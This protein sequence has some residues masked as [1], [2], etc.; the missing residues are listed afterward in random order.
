MR[1]QV[2]CKLRVAILSNEYPPFIF[3]GIGTFCQ[4]LAEALARQGVEVLVI[5]GSPEKHPKRVRTDELHPVEIIWLPRGPIPPRHLWFQ[6]RNMNEI[7]R[8]LATCDVVHGQDSSSF[9]MLQFCLRSGLKIP[10]VITFHTNPQAEL[11]FTLASILHGASLTDIATYLAGFPLW[12]ITVREHAKLAN[13]LVTVSRTLREEICRG[14]GV[15]ETRISAIPTCVDIA[16]LRSVL[17]NRRRRTGTTVRLFN[18]GRLYYR[19]G[20]LRLLEVA[21]YLVQD[22]AVRNFELNI[23]GAGPLE[24]ASRSY[25]SR[26]HLEANVKLR[27]F[28][29]RGTLLN[30]LADSDIVCVPSYYEACPV[31]MIEA[32]A[33]GKP[34]VAFNLPYAREMLPN[35]HQMLAFDE[36]DF[37]AKLAQLISSEEDRSKLGSI[38]KNEAA[39]FNSE[40]VAAS[41]CNI[42]QSLT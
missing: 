24:E 15:D 4:N 17:P 7:K 42:Y 13:S 31:S 10:W 27:G 40:K 16:N 32:M 21:R 25:V 19:K 11:H 3:G 23:F 39:K 35:E 5:G 2:S 41:Y 28:V 34:V 20:I 38:T 22:L 12:D 14:Y 29:P 9:P 6:L 30:E 33:F 18:A 36:M 26:N 8:Q 37:A 1:L